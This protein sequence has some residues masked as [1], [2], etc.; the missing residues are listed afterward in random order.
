MPDRIRFEHQ[1]LASGQHAV[2][3]PDIRGFCIVAATP[4]QAVDQAMEMLMVMRR[5]DGDDP[6]GRIAAVEFEAA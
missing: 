3:S 2:T 5:R 4:E 1:T 6:H